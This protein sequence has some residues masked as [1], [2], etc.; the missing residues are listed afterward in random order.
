MKRIGIVDLGSNSVRMSIIW[1]EKDHSYHMI[2]QAKSMVRLSEGMSEDANLSPQAMERTKSALSM[3]KKLAGVHQVDEIRAVATAAVRQAKNRD[4]FLDLVREETD[5]EL[6]VIS[7]EKE[8]YYDY[9]GVVNTLPLQ[10][11]VLM[12]IGGG[13]TELAWIE[14]RQL[15]EAVS[16]PLGAVLL[17]ESHFPEGEVSQKGIDEA[18]EEFD[19]VLDEIEWLDKV[20]GLPVVGLG[21]TWR[22]IAK[23]DRS[24]TRNSIQRIHGYVL[25]RKETLEWVEDLWGMSRK[26]RERAKGISA[27]RAEVI[28]GGIVP[29]ERVIKRLKPKAVVISGNGVREGLFYEAY[30]KMLKKPVVVENVLM[31]SLSNIVKRYHESDHHLQQLDRLTRV[32]YDA[33][34]PHYHF[35]ERDGELL[36]AAIRLHDIGMRIDYFNHQDHS[37]YLTLNTNLYGLTHR[38]LVQVAW[39]AGS[40]RVD[41]KLHQSIRQ[42]SGYMNSEE[43]QRMEQ[44][45]AILMIAEQLDRAEDSRV[46][47]FSA[48]VTDR[49]LILTA[50]SEE[51]I[52]L[53]I[54]SARRASAA[55]RKAYRRTLLIK[56]NK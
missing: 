40:H 39:I 7:G 24:A 31:H 52:D 8:A 13:S 1:V 12:D 43:K 33:L 25:E 2:E 9:L 36:Q 23:L 28:V 16:L 51:P 35:S 48:S 14:N 32:I 38:E 44:L 47:N 56:R 17:T 6:Q 11:F 21:G 19:Q 49:S 41:R 50:G 30:F 3:F 10:D 18:K 53:E 15:K 4:V 20:K 27:A 46:T 37:F 45:G 26:E 42:F 55:F 54:S 29:I 22:S 34:Q 5:W